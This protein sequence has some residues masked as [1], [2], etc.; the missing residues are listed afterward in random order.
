MTNRSITVTRDIDAPPEDVWKVLADFPNIAAW[1]TGVKASHTIG[2]A[3]GGVGARRHCDLAPAGGLDETIVE[4][5]E[6]RRLVVTIDRATV[7]PI[8]HATVT[9]TLDPDGAR[10][11]TSIE[12][13][14][15]PKGGPLGRLAGRLLDRQLAKGFDG[16]LID[17]ETAART[18]EEQR[19]N[20]PTRPRPSPASGAPA[21]TR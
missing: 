11:P 17:V 21:S 5:V 9:F 13:R 4:W 8:K 2:D 6:G 14:Y 7:V 15:R 10:T 1:N 20:S 3:T 16:F 12:Y 18:I 19:L